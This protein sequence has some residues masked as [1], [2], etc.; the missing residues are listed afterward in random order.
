MHRTANTFVTVEHSRYLATH[1]QDARLVE[2]GGD[3]HMPFLGDIDA[4]LEAFAA[5]VDDVGNRRR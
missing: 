2:M 4:V 1:L 5:F 3:S